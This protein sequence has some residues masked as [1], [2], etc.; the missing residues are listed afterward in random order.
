MPANP[1]H[2]PEI[3]ALTSL[4]HRII[5]LSEKNPLNTNIQKHLTTTYL[6]LK[7]FYFY[8]RSFRGLS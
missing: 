7:L 5:K 3:N 6:L 1:T 8:N 2:F 4:H